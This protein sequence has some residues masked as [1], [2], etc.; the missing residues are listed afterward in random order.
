VYKSPICKEAHDSILS[1]VVN[2]YKGNKNLL[3]GFEP[4]RSFL[5][6]RAC[7]SRVYILLFVVGV[8]VGV[9]VVVVDALL[10]YC[11]FRHGCMSS[12]FIANFVMVASRVVVCHV[13]LKF[14]LIC[15]AS[16][17]ASICVDAM[18]IDA[19]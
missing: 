10:N 11:E 4:R 15:V 2:E 5:P 19:N 8:G 6:A 16:M 1:L 7:S 13:A 9:G 18:Q 14:A 3:A 17:F 12:K